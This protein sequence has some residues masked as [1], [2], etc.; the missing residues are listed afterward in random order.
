MDG[1]KVD[2]M[3]GGRNQYI[4]FDKIEKGCEGAYNFYINSLDH[5][6]ASMFEDI[7]DRLL[8]AVHNIEDNLTK[9]INKLRQEYHERQKVE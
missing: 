6:V 2:T 4:M 1:P 5:P 7:D 8:D 3:I 9:N